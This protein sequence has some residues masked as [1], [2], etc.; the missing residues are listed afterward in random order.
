MAGRSKEKLERLRGELAAINPACG[1]VP[2]LTAELTDSKSLDKLMKQSDVI[3]S[4]AGP[5]WKLGLPLVRILSPHRTAAVASAEMHRTHACFVA[6]T[7]CMPLRRRSERP[8]RTQVEA[9]IRNGTHYC[10]I[11]GEVHFMRKTTATLH[12]SAAAKN[13]KVVH[14][15]GFDSVPSDLGTLLLVQHMKTKLGRA[16]ARVDLLVNDIKGAQS[17]GSL[18]SMFEQYLLPTEEVALCADPFCLNPPLAAGG[19]QREA[20]ADE[21]DHYGLRYNSRLKRWTYP[22]QFAPI[23]ARVVRRSNGFLQYSPNFKC[24]RSPYLVPC[25]GQAVQCKRA[26][27]RRGARVQ[28]QRGARGRGAHRRDA[29]CH[30]AHVRAPLHHRGLPA[31]LCDTDAAQTRRRPARGL[32]RAQPLEV[33][34]ARL[35]G[36][37]SA[38]QGQ[39]VRGAPP[40]PACS[41][42]HLAPPSQAQSASM[43]LY[44]SR[45]LWHG[46]QCSRTFCALTATWWV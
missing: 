15:C 4:V 16:C 5:F 45:C 17:G 26:T 37:G 34:A 42:T 19:T 38:R 44:R 32:P 33:H 3:V 6:G 8:A 18:Q 9:A 30:R 28:I 29:G 36:G 41:L 13:V 11:A 2:I 27:S 46:V 43:A 10:D 23:N 35:D 12:A 40:S 25:G 31:R 22:F 39:A 7:A 21:R 24:A 1:A 20:T 14:S